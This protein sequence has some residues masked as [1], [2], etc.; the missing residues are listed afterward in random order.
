VKPG[1]AGVRGLTVLDRSVVDG[2]AEG[3]A[4][5]LTAIAMTA[6][7]VQNGLVRSYALTLLGGAALVLLTL[8]AVNYG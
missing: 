4:V 5:A 6:R 3:V 7:K 1:L 2:L 8:L